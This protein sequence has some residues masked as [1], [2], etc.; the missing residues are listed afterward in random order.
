M[1]LT[2]GNLLKMKFLADFRSTEPE[3]EFAKL[4]VIC[5]YTRD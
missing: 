2:H 1:I 3:S 5:G 4:E